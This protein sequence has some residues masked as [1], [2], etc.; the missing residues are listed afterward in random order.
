MIKKVIC[1]ECGLEKEHHAKGLCHKCYRKHRKDIPIICKACNQSKPHHAF[2]LCSNCYL[3]KHHYDKI[4]ESNIMKWHN[5]SLDRWKGITKKCFLCDFDK[6]VELHHIDGNHK[7]ISDNNLIG[8]CPNHH[9]MLHNSK[10]SKEIKEEISIRL[11][12]Y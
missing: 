4:K 7:N 5:I 1:K 12:S 6:I 2:G 10:Y 11:R 3:K 8:L 9:K